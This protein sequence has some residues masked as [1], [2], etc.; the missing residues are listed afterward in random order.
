MIAVNLL[1]SFHLLRAAAAA[2]LADGADEGDEAG[3]IVMTASIAAYDGQIGQI[4]YSA[5]KGGVVGHDP[6]GGARPRER[7]RS[8]SARS[9]RGCSTRRCS[10]A[11]PRRRAPR[12]A[13][14]SR[15]PRASALPE[16][17]A[18]LAAHIVANPML[19]GEVVRLDG[20]L[21][22]PPRVTAHSA[23][24]VRSAIDDALDGRR[25]R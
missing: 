16:E 20:A 14:R 7:A 15:I 24:R 3:V 2:M 18:A 22:M 6:A 17:Y 12:S 8:A 13:R 19:N 25:A 4:A 10:P 21:R 5:S 1:G 23:G 11:C 9:R